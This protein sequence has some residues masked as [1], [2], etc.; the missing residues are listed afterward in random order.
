MDTKKDILSAYEAIRGFFTGTANGC[1]E[2][3]GLSIIL[4]HGM[5][6]FIRTYE[7]QMKRDNEPTKKAPCSYCKG[8]PSPELVVLLANLF[9]R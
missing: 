2:T 3:R 8:E 4:T 7:T 1:A 5:G 9:W 6:T